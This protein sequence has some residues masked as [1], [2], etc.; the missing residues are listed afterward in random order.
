VQGEDDGQHVAD[1]RHLPAA[2]RGQVQ[3]GVG[4]QAEADALGD[5]EAERDAGD[6]QEGRGGLGEVVE[7][8]PR[9]RLEHEDAHHH[10]RGRRRRGRDGQDHRREEQRQQEEHRRGRAGQAGAAARLDA[11]GGLDVADHRRGA[12][13]RAQDG[14]ERVGHEGAAGL[15]QPAVPVQQPGAL[16]HPDERADVVEHVDQQQG[17]DDGE[18]LAKIVQQQ[19]EVQL[20]HRRRG[21]GGERKQRARQGRDAAALAIRHDEPDGGDGEDGEDDG[22]RHAAGD[23]HGGQQDAA[24]AEQDAWRAEVAVGDE[25]RGVGHDDAAVLQPDEGDEEADA[26]GDGQLQ[27]VRDGLDDLLAH[28][29]DREGEEDAAVDEDQA[30]GRL[31]RHAE[32]EADG[33]GE[34]GVDAHARGEGEG[35]V[36]HEAH[37]QRADGGGQRRDGDERGLRHACGGEDGGI[38]REDV[39]HRGEGGRAGLQLARDGG[40]VLGQPVEFL[41]HGEGQGGAGRLRMKFTV[42]SVTARAACA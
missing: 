11:R 13:Q 12:E 10:Q 42:K 2:A 30:E 37:Q 41:Q 40:A 23:E 33:E 31:P 25:G 18:G 21:R 15:G 20:E 24:E 34:V 27:L 35:V 14:G 4:D 28:A 26:A 32:G 39:G 16:R 17:E 9:H 19:V 3:H 8:Q 7:V 36:G 22:A 5:A 6:D 29:G 1:G 38:D